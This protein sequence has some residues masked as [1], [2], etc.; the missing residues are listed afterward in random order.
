MR[1]R[2]RILVL[3]AL[4]GA[5]CGLPDNPTD[6]APVPDTG[7]VNQGP[8]ST[9]NPTTTTPV[10]G[11]PAASP[12]PTP[13]PGEDPATGG[14][15]GTSTPPPDATPPPSPEASGCSA[16]YPPD[17]A[18]INVKI[19]IR[20]SEY[21]TLDSTPLIG[22]NPAYCAQIGYTDGREYCP[23]RPD[24]HPEREACEAW[25]VGTARDTGRV[26]PTWT[27][28]GGACR[29]SSSGCQNSPEN[30]YQALA[31]AS[32]LFQ[33]CARNGACGEV[34]VDR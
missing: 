34:A 10:L 17:V 14:G 33:A 20:G 24:G 32:G 12:T 13:D 9:G 19:H 7:T 1:A 2:R 3:A 25:A 16:P 29:G 4:V 11:S 6:P 31:F 5:A 8:P 15:D 27:R 28:N 30:Q 26:G 18:R 22:P 21:W 23:V